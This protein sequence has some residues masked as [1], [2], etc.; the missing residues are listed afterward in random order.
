[1]VRLIL[2]ILKEN[3]PSKRITQDVR[4]FS[5][6]LVNRALIYFSNIPKAYSLI[7]ERINY[8]DS[9]KL[10]QHDD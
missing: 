4:I 9:F 2:K 3:H 5:F 6:A 1:M 10:L 8:R 7:K